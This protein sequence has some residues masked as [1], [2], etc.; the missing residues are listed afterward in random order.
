MNCYPIII[1]TLDVNDKTV[2]IED[3]R[4]KSLDYVKKEDLLYSAVTSKAVTDVFAENEGYIVHD[5]TEGK[6]LKMG[7]T[8]AWIFENIDEARRKMNEIELAR[9]DSKEIRATNKAKEIAAQKNID[10]KKI[11]KKGLITEKDVLSYL[12]NTEE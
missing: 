11:P 10:L 2:V 5:L 6:E 8:V 3:I 4:V 12:E 9:S 1:P 7:D